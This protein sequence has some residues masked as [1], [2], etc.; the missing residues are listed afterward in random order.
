LL[1]FDELHVHDSGDAR[2][3]TRLLE[4][5]FTRRLT[6]LA[7]SNYAPA[8][9]LP[10]PTWHHTFEPGIALLT[11]NLDVVA[12]RGPVDYRTMRDDHSRGFAAGTWST[13]APP[14]TPP[15]PET[16]TVGGRSFEVAATGD[17]A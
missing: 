1:F 2:L 13:G 16:V 7:T 15:E 8:E 14:Q 17:G 10:N 11:Q 6:V 12:L 3:L 4:H 5:V 9:L